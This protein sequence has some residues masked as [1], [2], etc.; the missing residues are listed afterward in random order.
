M[1]NTRGFSLI[2]MIVVISIIVVFTALTTIYI[3]NFYSNSALRFAALE[4]SATLDQARSLAITKQTQYKVVFDDSANKYVVKDS[5]DA[6]ADKEH[7]LK[8]GITIFLINFSS[9]TVT[10]GSDGGANNG[11]VIIKD[12]T[13]KYFTIKVLNSTG[14]IKVL[15]YLEMP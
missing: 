15:N 7:Y 12:K 5:L 13:D 6:D 2:E 8:T 1:K 3:F 14:R 11:R 10:Y 4:V 9:K